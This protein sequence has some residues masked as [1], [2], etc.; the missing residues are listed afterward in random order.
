M[1][2]YSKFRINWTF[3]TSK[4]GNLEEIRRNTFFALDF[5]VCKNPTESVENVY[6]FLRSTINLRKALETEI[7][8]TPWE[9]VFTR[10]QNTPQRVLSLA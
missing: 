7:L 4:V 1:W 9:D 10:E 2:F 8:R 6:L 5:S 3:R